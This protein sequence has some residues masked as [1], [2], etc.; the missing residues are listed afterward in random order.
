[1]LFPPSTLGFEA[2]FAAEMIL[3][4]ECFHTETGLCF[5]HIVPRAAAEGCCDGN[6]TYF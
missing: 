5:F 1:M 3:P 4:H 2:C 6:V